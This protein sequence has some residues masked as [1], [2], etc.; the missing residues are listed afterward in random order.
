MPWD[1]IAEALAQHLR[2]LF[3]RNEDAIRQNARDN[4]DTPLE[5]SVE[6]FS[7]AMD[8]ATVA[9]RDIDR[10]VIDDFITQTATI[11]DDF[12]FT[13]NA[14]EIMRFYTQ[15]NITEGIQRIHS[16]EIF[17]QVFEEDRPAAVSKALEQT[18][19][20]IDNFAA[21]ESS[22]SFALKHQALAIANDFR[23]YTYHTSEDEVVR[24][25][26]SAR[27]GRAFAYGQER[28]VDDVPGLAARCRCFASPITFE[29][30]L[31]A[32]F[33]YPED[34]PS[35]QADMSKFK[36]N[37]T[38]PGVAVI[39]VEGVIEDLDQ[40]DYATFAEKVKAYL[41][42]ESTRLVVNVTSYGGN[43]MD[44]ALAY[45][46][47]KS[48]PNH[49][50]TNVY[51]FCGSAATYFVLAADVSTIGENDEFF[52][53]EAWTCIPCGNKRQ[54]AKSAGDAIEQLTDFDQ[55]QVEMYAA[56]TG[57][58]HEEINSLLE[59]AKAL[60][61][62]F[63]KDFGFFDEIRPD[64]N[65]SKSARGVPMAQANI[66][67][68]KAQK[69]TGEPMDLQAILVALSANAELKAQ[70][71]K[72]LGLDSVDELKAQI[73]TL[74]TSNTELNATVLARDAV[75]NA[76]QSAGGEVSDEQRAAIFAEARELIKTEAAAIAKISAEVVDAGFTVE[77]ETVSEIY[78]NAIDQA[79]SSSKGL[80]DESLPVVWAAVYPLHKGKGAAKGEQDDAQ[81]NALGN[82][83]GEQVVTV[84]SRAAAINSA[85]A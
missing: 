39:D 62:V 13:D 63:A 47:L 85:H 67:A 70:V 80:S 56:K 26:H 10:A 15:K 33:F 29:E 55:L 32:T 34:K 52:I 41:P 82:A 51:G 76:H 65:R 23:Y 49:V 14:D 60:S 48:L 57:R 7:E 64:C 27:N 31:E 5:L 59:E 73:A 83:D 6:D 84:A 28:I 11:V 24:G 54:I 81:I 25:S 71:L 58:T 19:S 75:I 74:T 40:N 50:T 43:G 68:L 38:Q 20:L 8:A 22:S 21:S 36:I 78:A 45:N 3:E 42:D 44:G 61:A 72:E 9:V 16:A 18:F 53:H 12:D 35:V 77:G 1:D 2:S 30:A 4:P 69:S 79:G 17:K 46:L 66:N 37:A